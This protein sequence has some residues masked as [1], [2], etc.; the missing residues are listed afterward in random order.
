MLGSGGPGVWAAAPMIGTPKNTEHSMAAI[1]SA[2]PRREPPPA[3]STATITQSTPIRNVSH[4][5]PHS[6]Q[7]RPHLQCT[8]SRFGWRTRASLAVCAVR[9]MH[10]AL[11]LD[12]GDPSCCSR[13]LSRATSCLA[14]LGPANDQAYWN[15]DRHA[16]RY[17]DNLGPLFFKCSDQ[18]T[19]GRRRDYRLGLDRPPLLY[20]CR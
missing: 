16:C 18:E 13:R 19:R 7:P 10:A 11:L 9:L 2:K 3:V 4:A 5:A 17:L 14:C 1:W 12:L 15:N 8:P 6:E 20:L